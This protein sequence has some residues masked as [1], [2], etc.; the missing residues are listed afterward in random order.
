[1][2]KAKLDNATAADLERLCAEF[3]IYKD[4]SILINHY[5][6]Y[7]EWFTLPDSILE[8]N[9]CD[10]PNQLSFRYLKTVQRSSSLQ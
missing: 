1:M 6:L 4:G 7:D 3:E 2:A 5:S 10:M 9:F 8:I